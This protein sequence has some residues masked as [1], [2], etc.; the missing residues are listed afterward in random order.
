MSGKALLTLRVNLLISCY[1]SL[2][3]VNA[4]SLGKPLGQCHALRGSWLVIE[5]GRLWPGAWLLAFAAFVL[6]LTYLLGKELINSGGAFPAAIPGKS[7]Q[8]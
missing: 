1:F 6:G 4:V 2:A 3:N 5:T 7:N 8:Q